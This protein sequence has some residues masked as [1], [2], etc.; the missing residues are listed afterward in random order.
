MR[1]F[2]SLRADS[3]HWEKWQMIHIIRSTGTR[4]PCYINLIRTETKGCDF[5]DRAKIYKNQLLIQ[6]HQQKENGKRDIGHSMWTLKIY[7]IR[8][9][10]MC[11]WDINHVCRQTSETCRSKKCSFIILNHW[12]QGKLTRRSQHENIEIIEINDV[13]N[14]PPFCA[15][16]LSPSLPPYLFPS[17]SLFLSLSL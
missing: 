16:S 12:S 10:T 5:S 8:T 6:I 1:A 11:A 3:L 4:T 2:S 9:S 17:I 13:W 15:L 14:I 7:A